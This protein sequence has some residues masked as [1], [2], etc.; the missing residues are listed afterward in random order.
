MNNFLIIEDY[1][2]ES[3]WSVIQKTQLIFH[4][5][6]APYGKFDIKLF[7][8]RKRAKPFMLVVD[9]N[10]FSGLIHFCQNGFLKDERETQLIGILMTWAVLND[11]NITS[12]PAIMEYASGVHSQ[13]DALRELQKFKEIMERYPAQ[14]WLQVARQEL[15]KIPKCRFSNSVAKGISTDYAQGCEHYY[16]AV[17]SMLRLVQLYRNK[18]LS[19]MDKMLS[20]LEWT[21]DNAIV[22]GFI[23]IYAILLFTNQNGIKAPK[24]VN[25][26][27]IEQIVK[28]CENQAWDI[29]YLSNL[30]ILY[31]HHD[32]YTVDFLFATNDNMLKMIYING[33]APAGIN[34]LLYAAFSQ[35]QYDKI[36]AY[37][38]ERQSTREKPS[39]EENQ[40]KYYQKLIEREKES[41]QELLINEVK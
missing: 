22:S 12:G 1:E 34:G 23:I 20:F 36:C 29:T 37:I 6:I 26:T 24:G 18:K 27:N 19:P 8:D 4:P 21:Y 41:L 10:I 15:T 5:E 13:E 39:F 35:K 28:G 33:N 38:E 16:L 30:S 9:R 14:T 2:I 25:S 32:D 17:A 7:M 40:T 31:A 3:L 11:V